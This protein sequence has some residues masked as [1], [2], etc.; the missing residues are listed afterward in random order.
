MFLQ[1]GYKIDFKKEDS[2]RDILGFDAVIIYQRYTESPK[3]CD[4]V[5]LTNSFIYLDIV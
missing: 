1:Q 2:L 3:I 4:L 5:I